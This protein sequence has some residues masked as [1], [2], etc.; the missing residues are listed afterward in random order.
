MCTNEDAYR[1]CDCVT[2]RQV[3]ILP[4]DNFVVCPGVNAPVVLL[5]AIG[6]HQMEEVQPPSPGSES[7]FTISGAGIV[8][9]NGNLGGTFEY[10]RHGPCVGLHC[11]MCV[12][13]SIQV[14]MDYGSTA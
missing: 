13:R 11:V 6:V 14:G 5:G 1:H 2:V 3:G 12:A 8:H 9:V 7:R 10:G 4:R